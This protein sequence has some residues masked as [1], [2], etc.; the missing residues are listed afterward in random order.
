MWIHRKAVSSQV[1]KEP[2]FL[3]FFESATE[4]T[5][6]ETLRAVSSQRR[7][8]VLGRP[9]SAA[10]LRAFNQSEDVS[11]QTNSKGVSAG[12]RASLGSVFGSSLHSRSRPRPS[13][14]H[15]SQLLRG[16]PLEYLSKLNSPSFLLSLSVAFF[17]VAL[18]TA[19]GSDF[20][21]CASGDGGPG[22]P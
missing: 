13:G 7:G 11:M 9:A 10:C 17:V 22:K 15:E 12:G 5:M 20:L 19:S 1:G 3:A 2:P 18:R 21:A 16:K 14:G 4:S 6:P 8:S